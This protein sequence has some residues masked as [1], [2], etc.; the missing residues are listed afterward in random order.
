V[1]VCLTTTVTA[2]TTTATA[3]AT[4]AVSRRSC[5]V[6][7]EDERVEPCAV[8]S[9]NGFGRVVMVVVIDEGKA[10]AFPGRAVL[11]VRE[12]ERARERER[13]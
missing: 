1:F 6:Y 8:Q 5:P 10:T 13:D 9:L 12:T 3:T 7:V 11:K 2:T 4:A